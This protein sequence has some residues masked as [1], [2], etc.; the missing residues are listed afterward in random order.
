MFDSRKKLIVP[1]LLTDVQHKSGRINVN[2]SVIANFVFD[3]MTDDVLANRY[4]EADGLNDI[5]F[6]NERFEKIEGLT[7]EIMTNAS[8]SDGEFP[9]QSIGASTRSTAILTVTNGSLIHGMTAS[10]KITLTSTDGTIVDYFISNTANGSAGSGHVANLGIVTSGATLDSGKTASLTL[11]AV[12]IAIGFNLGAPLAPGIDQAEFLGLLKAAIEHA[13]GH[14]GKIIVG[15]APSAANTPQTLSLTQTV[16]GFSGNEEITNNITNISVTSFTRRKYT[17]NTSI[18]FKSFLVS[19]SPFKSRK[20]EIGDKSFFTNYYFSYRPENYS[21][22]ILTRYNPRS[23]SLQGSSPNVAEISVG[24]HIKASRNIISGS[25]LSLT[26]PQVG[27]SDVTRNYSSLFF[28]E[29]AK[30]SSLTL[31]FLEDYINS[32][33]TFKLTDGQK[34]DFS[35]SLADFKSSPTRKIFKVDSEATVTFTTGSVTFVP[36]AGYDLNN[37]F[38]CFTTGSSYEKA[39]AS[40]SLDIITSSKVWV[41][42]FVNATPVSSGSASVTFAFQD[43]PD[44]ANT[45]TTQL[46]N[47]LY[48]NALDTSK[49]ASQRLYLGTP[50]QWAGLTGASSGGKSTFSCWIQPVENQ[51]HTEDHVIFS[52]QQ[53]NYL[54]SIPDSGKIKFTRNFSSSTAYTVETEKP[55]FTVANS[56]AER[57]PAAQWTHICITYNGPAYNGTASIYINGMPVAMASASSTPASDKTIINVSGTN[58]AHRTTLGDKP[59]GSRRLYSQFAD[60]GFWNK[61][62]TAGEIYDLYSR[63]LASYRANSNL[64]LHINLGKNIKKTGALAITPSYTNVSAFENVTSKNAIGNHQYT[65]YKFAGDTDSVNIGTAAQWDATIGDNTGASSTEKMSFSAWINKTADGGGNLGRIFDFGQSDIFLYSTG[66]EELAFSSRLNNAHAEWRTGPSSF[67]LNQWVHVAVTYDASD[68]LNNDPVIYVN[69]QRVASS[70]LGSS[71][72]KHA[73]YSGIATEAGYIGNRHTHD[74]AFNGEITEVAI[75]NSLLSDS[76]VFAI[77]FATRNHSASSLKEVAINLSKAINNDSTINISATNPNLSLRNP[78]VKIEQNESLIQ[79]VST[80]TSSYPEKP[81]NSQSSALI[82]YSSKDRRDKKCAL[83]SNSETATTLFLEKIISDGKILTVKDFNDISVNFTFKTDGT[84][85]N[86]VATNSIINIQNL[87]TKLAIRDKVKA[88]INAN[89]SSGNSGTLTGISLNS[90]ENED[91]RM[92][93]RPKQKFTIKCPDAT[94]SDQKSIVITD[95]TGFSY[96]LFFRK[97]ASAAAPAGSIAVTYANSADSSAVATALESV[98]ENLPA[99]NR[100]GANAMSS[101]AAFSASVTSEQVTVLSNAF[102]LCEIP[103]AYDLKTKF[104]IV[105]I[106]DG[107]EKAGAITATGTAISDSFI[108]FNS[109][110]YSFPTP[111]YNVPAT[112]QKILENSFDGVGI[113]GPGDPRINNVVVRYTNNSNFV[114]FFDNFKTAIS[115]PQAAGHIV[116]GKQVIG[117]SIVGPTLEKKFR[118]STLKESKTILRLRNSD[119][120]YPNTNTGKGIITFKSGSIDLTTKVPTLTIMPFS[121]GHVNAGAMTRNSKGLVS[122]GKKTIITRVYNNSSSGTGTI[123][124]V[125]GTTSSRWQLL[126][127][128]GNLEFRIRPNGSSAAGDYWKATIDRSALAKDK[129]YTLFITFDESTFNVANSKNMFA[130]YD[131]ENHGGLLS[132]TS[133]SINNSA[134]SG[135]QSAKLTLGGSP[136]LFIGYGNT[137]TGL[138][139]NYGNS[140]PGTNPADSASFYNNFNIAELSILSSQLVIT[141]MAK[142]AESHLT[143]RSKSGFRNQLPKKLLQEKYQ[144]SKNLEAN[145]KPFKEDSSTT[146][147]YSSKDVVFPSNLDA[148]TTGSISFKFTNSP[149]DNSGFSLRL[150]NGKDFQVIFDTSSTVADGFSLDSLTSPIKDANH[151]SAPLASLTRFKCGLSGAST[152]TSKVD[153]IKTFINATNRYSGIPVKASRV[154]F[155][156]IR[157]EML[158]AGSSTPEYNSSAK[159]VIFNNTFDPSNVAASSVLQ[160]ANGTTTVNYTATAAADDHADADKIGITTNRSV[161]D[162]VDEFVAKINAVS[163]FGITA[164]DQGNYNGDLTRAS[165][166]LVPDSGKD[167]II[168]ENPAGN[169]EFGTSSTFCQ[170][171]PASTSLALVSSSPASN[172]TILDNTLSSQAFGDSSFD[173]FSLTPRK[174]SI[175]AGFTQDT[176][177]A[178]IKCDVSKLNELVEASSVTRDYVEDNLSN[179]FFPPRGGLIRR[180]VNVQ[181]LSR[182]RKDTEIPLRPAIEFSIGG[183]KYCARV[184]SLLNPSNS[185]KYNIGVKEVTSSN[186]LAMSLANSINDAVVFDN[187][188][189]TVSFSNDVVTLT[190]D[191]KNIIPSR[192][193]ISGQGVSSESVF[194]TVGYNTTRNPEISERSRESLVVKKSS[195]VSSPFL[196]D[197]KNDIE[198][199]F[200]SMGSYLSGSAGSFASATRDRVRIE[201]DIN[202]VSKTTLGFTTGSGNTLT[203]GFA[204]GN[205]N[206]IGYF[207]FASKKWESISPTFSGKIE[208]KRDAAGAGQ[209]RD[210]AIKDAVS[211]FQKSAPIAFGGTYGF[212][213]HRKN[214]T[215]AAFTEITHVSGSN[216][217]DSHFT[218][219]SLR[220]NQSI[221]ITSTDGTE[222]DYVMHTL[223][224]ADSK[225]AG[226]ALTTSM[227]NQW[228]GPNA[229][230]YRRSEQVAKDGAYAIGPLELADNF[231]SLLMK[232]KAAIAT[233]HAGKIICSNVL[234]DL[235]ESWGTVTFLQTNDSPLVTIPITGNFK[236]KVSKGFDKAYASSDILYFYF[237]INGSPNKSHYISVNVSSISGTGPSGHGDVVTVTRNNSNAKRY[238]TL[239]DTVTVSSAMLLYCGHVD[240]LDDSHVSL[241]LT[242]AVLGAAGNTRIHNGI[243][244]FRIPGHV[245]S[246]FSL[247][248]SQNPSPG[249]ELTVFGNNEINKTYGFVNTPVGFSYGS[250]PISFE[251][252]P[253]SATLS[254]GF[255][256][257]GGNAA[258]T[259]KQATA[260]AVNLGSGNDLGS[261]TKHVISLGGFDGSGN[262]GEIRISDKIPYGCTI[263]IEF[264]ATREDIIGGTFDASTSDTT[265]DLVLEY[266]STSNFSTTV[267][268]VNKRFEKS[269]N[270]GGAY[271][272]TTDSGAGRI[273]GGDLP[274]DDDNTSNTATL[275]KFRINVTDMPVGGSYL[276][277]RKLV[278]AIAGD[279]IIIYNFKYTLTEGSFG[280]PV[281]IRSSLS[282]TI[283]AL[284]TELGKNPNIQHSSP[285]GSDVLEFRPYGDRV[286]IYDHGVYTTTSN[287]EI[288]ESKGFSNS[289]ND[290][291]NGKYTSFVG[292]ILTEENDPN[293]GSEYSKLHYAELPLRGRPVSNFGFPFS[294]TFKPTDGQKLDLSSYLDG[295]FLLEKFEIICSSSIRDEVQEGMGRLLPESAI[296][297]PDSNYGQSNSNSTSFSKQKEVYD[298]KSAFGGYFGL[299]DDRFRNLEAQRI[300]DRYYPWTSTGVI[301]SALSNSSS[302]SYYLVGT[303]SAY[304]R[305]RGKSTFTKEKIKKEGAYHRV[306]G[307]VYAREGQ[308]NDYINSTTGKTNTVEGSAWWRCDTFFLLR[309]K[310]CVDTT[311]EAAIPKAIK[312]S[313]LETTSTVVGGKMYFGFHEDSKLIINIFGTDYQTDPANWPEIKDAATG[314]ISWHEY[315]TGEARDQSPLGTI[316]STLVITTTPKWVEIVSHAPVI[317]PAVTSV[318]DGVK[319]EVINDAGEN[320]NAGFNAVST[321]YDVGDIITC[322]STGT[323]S[324]TTNT[325]LREVNPKR[326]RI[327]IASSVTGTSSPILQ[328]LGS[329][330]EAQ[331]RDGSIRYAIDLA[332]TNWTTYPVTYLIAAFIYEIIGAASAAGYLSGITMKPPAGTDATMELSINNAVS[333]DFDGGVLNTSASIAFNSGSRYS[334]HYR[335]AGAGGSWKLSGKIKYFTDDLGTVPVEFSN[336][337]SGATPESL[338]YEGASIERPVTIN[339]VTSGFNMTTQSCQIT[340]TTRELISYAQVAYHGYANQNSDSVSGTG[341]NDG[342]MAHYY[343]VNDPAY[344]F[345]RGTDHT[346]A[347]SGSNKQ[348]MEHPHQTRFGSFESTGSNGFNLLENGLGRELNI[349]IGTQA[350]LNPHLD[351]SHTTTVSGNEVRGLKFSIPKFIPSAGHATKR[352]VDIVGDDGLT[353]VVTDTDDTTATKSPTFLS[354]IRF[355]NNEINEKYRQKFTHLTSS[356]NLHD[357]VLRIKAVCKSTPKLDT[358]FSYR[359]AVLDQYNNPSSQTLPKFVSVSPQGAFLGGFD[360]DGVGGTRALR[361][362]TGDEPSGINFKINQMPFYLDD[363][364]RMDPLKQSFDS[365]FADSISTG[366][367]F[368]VGNAYVLKPS[369]K[370]TLGFQTAVPGFHSGF[371]SFANLGGGST[372]PELDDQGNLQTVNTAQ[373]FITGVTTAKPPVVTTA[374]YHELRDGNQIQIKDVATGNAGTALNDVYFRVRV[375]SNRTFELYTDGDLANPV[376]FTAAIYSSG[377]YYYPPKY[378]RSRAIDTGKCIETTFAPYSNSKLVLYGSYLQN[379]VP[380][381]P[382]HK[383]SFSTSGVV[384]EVIGQEDYDKF[385][386]SLDSEFSGSMSSEIISK[387]SISFGK[388]SNNDIDLSKIDVAFGERTNDIGGS[389]KKLFA[390]GSVERYTALSAGDDVDLVYWDSLPVNITPYFKKKHKTR[391]IIPVKFLTSGSN[392]PLITNHP[393]DDSGVAL[394]IGSPQQGTTT[395]FNDTLTTLNSSFPGSQLLTYQ[396]ATINVGTANAINLMGAKTGAKVIFS[397]G[398]NPERDGIKFEITGISGTNINVSFISSGSFIES[399]GITPSTVANSNPCRVMVFS[400]FGD[401]LESTT[402]LPISAFEDRYFTEWRKRFIFEKTTRDSDGKEVNIFGSGGFD[403]ADSKLL[404]RNDK[405]ATFGLDLPPSTMPAGFSKF[406]PVLNIFQSPNYG[407]GELLLT[408]GSGAPVTYDISKA[409]QKTHLLAA[410]ANVKSKAGVFS[411]RY[412]AQTKNVYIASKSYYPSLYTNCV[413]QVNDSPY[414]QAAA[415]LFGFGKEVNN[416]LETINL[417]SLSGTSAIPFGNV[418]DSRTSTL[419]L[420][421]RHTRQTLIHPAGVKYGMMNYDMLRP[422][423][424]FSR[425][426]FG[427]FCDLIEGRKSGVFANLSSIEYSEVGPDRRVPTVEVSFYDASMALIKSGEDKLKFLFS[428]NLDRYQRSRVPFFDT[429]NPNLHESALGGR[430]RRKADIVNNQVSVFNSDG[431]DVFDDFN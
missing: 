171:I 276:R 30:K 205:Y 352:N 31:S 4:L 332:W 289:A 364:D 178:T 144:E 302:N 336:T 360:H 250:D 341:F 252:D 122:L 204:A 277:V 162:A 177:K 291:W 406:S 145:F 368:E 148:G 370:I 353:L 296:D 258:M 300:Y 335:P 362:V 396:T 361:A 138:A 219:P 429:P 114:D 278:S 297:L 309:E 184:D 156:T 256:I 351:L 86:H 315:I 265:D 28:Q 326:I 60:L 150:P 305:L 317:N 274:A 347:V 223:T 64:Q 46:V 390:T 152:I 423:V 166:L 419:K 108:S 215:S 312:S 105:S 7:N 82:L 331:K 13:N 53:D 249:D 88:A 56:S 16:G 146:Q 70:H 323:V 49:D 412:D 290:S 292:G 318:I 3:R 257:V 243:N 189:I 129:W 119:S 218:T 380:K 111:Q 397:T 293:K 36:N 407:S 383:S 63:P 316:A 279:S 89:V 385:D 416:N 203:S 431:N 392:K 62:L 84:A 185:N 375:L 192:T 253:S 164:I 172:I 169:K 378:V 136:R 1:D 319:Y 209:S 151:I 411:A 135:D 327:Y 74:R 401:S 376:D 354:Q 113:V 109:N 98:I 359:L 367:N 343:F 241:K 408:S 395:F 379:S 48:R 344:M 174:D 95:T 15:S 199:N 207:D 153:R 244:G 214:T 298:D 20:M 106:H 222:I 198:D 201:I 157:I 26:V 374:T 45:F 426:K 133:F 247:K 97:T 131:S 212:S 154:A 24:S 81:S 409:D 230:L 304:H 208:T 170:I 377:G 44:D 254:A 125:S 9:R 263:T 260:C 280:S 286:A 275:T 18:D 320:L 35:I 42:N 430:V 403:P 232:L 75:W 186:Q 308:V 50:D 176:I 10:Q 299:Y 23:L 32:D 139:T 115:H 415:I 355:E 57:F 217:N 242:Q 76:E 372:P 220:A 405:E 123:F 183:K 228:I 399:S 47:G 117:S 393:I 427:N 310:Q 147:A 142:I 428:Q 193:I 140:D 195:L 37:K 165:M 282:D 211:I 179:R 345:Y 14:N 94:E 342:S 100:T 206:P 363:F 101:G 287:V 38:N 264:W 160:I 168:L 19:N 134:P 68:T 128:D 388:D 237:E 110:S 22:K 51:G 158:D 356:Y 271:V 417:G 194:E 255:Q 130:L 8:G 181:F 303:G 334:S 73:T 266:C 261:G 41:G 373:V 262:R 371:T 66:T 141:E 229:P 324:G 295:P 269:I 270:N 11:G 25:V 200:F 58:N 422:K 80:L 413:N 118:N 340:S 245:R 103:T 365:T 213:L 366:K 314:N 425:S 17:E 54:I 124:T 163:G 191:D 40:G 234:P 357:G 127:I 27:S 96:R 294:D 238:T 224:G 210:D 246:T 338:V 173:D 21:S 268:T 389:P 337:P 190:V 43:A 251:D 90:V 175:I 59:A 91:I 281:P 120:V 391:K 322:T 83:F 339:G 71:Q 102:G 116:S 384:Y 167:L 180:L 121:R 79:S 346:S 420:I 239:L 330:T 227:N 61:I 52:S 132:S 39:Y 72:A 78:T 92:D 381:R 235:L 137:S 65:A 349:K 149:A 196:D 400:E 273:N 321:S 2:K 77:Y 313:G 288:T 418:D 306:G 369:D 85:D 328:N 382:K 325:K 12:G 126:S 398:S 301:W 202:P 29:R 307:N 358:Y 394:F 187:L 414:R 67:G 231:K 248:F 226:V 143:L 93:A 284:N 424:I 6:F 33:G 421:P 240:I 5:I 233:A 107:S 267:Y 333:D 259:L 182:G 283:I 236:I 159:I 387:T 285:V 225:S 112:G 404:F 87:S 272:S 348:T 161:T 55:V 216:Y 386:L 221:R 410:L 188:P 350:H 402:Q 329:F 311:F 155:D 104:I 69:G 34:A 197:G 99:S